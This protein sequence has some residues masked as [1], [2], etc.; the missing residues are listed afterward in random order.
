[1]SFSQEVIE[2][3]IE[4]ARIHR[5][6]CLDIGDGESALRIELPPTTEV[7][8]G[9]P[10]SEPAPTEHYVVRAPWVGYFHLPEQ[11]LSEGSLIEPDTPVGVIE[12]LGLPNEV[13]AGVRGIFEG[14]LV[15][16]GQP[17]EYGQPV[18][19]ILVTS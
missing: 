1:M 8:A 13:P 4:L 15:K 11:E 9:T 14:F 17:V 10:S 3:L 12:V 2:Q 5:L 18:A 6:T 7:P 16:E 19:K